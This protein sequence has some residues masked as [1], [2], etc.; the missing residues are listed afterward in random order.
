MKSFWSYIGVLSAFSLFTVA[1]RADSM[2]ILLDQ[3]NCSGPG[4][5]SVIGAGP[6]GVVD[7]TL[8]GGDIN[9]DV[10]M[11]EP[12]YNSGILGIFHGFAFN[13]NPAFGGAPS[14]DITGEPAGWSSTNPQAPGNTGGFGPFGKYDYV[15]DGP[16]GSGQTPGTGDCTSIGLCDALSFTVSKVGGSFT[17]V[18]ELIANNTDGFSFATDIRNTASTANTYKLA[19]DGLAAVPE[20]RTVVLLS[21]ALCGFVIVGRRRAAAAR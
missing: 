4:C 15:L 20:P 2:S 21:L 8:S 19:S 16:G 6:F 3:T 17:T 12:F 14:I 7:L 5:A 9:I 10:Q 11:Y 18:N 13:Y 1:A